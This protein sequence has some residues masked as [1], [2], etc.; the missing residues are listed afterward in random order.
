M[1]TVIKKLKEFT[2]NA[3]IDT[4]IKLSFLALCLF[5]LYTFVL[6]LIS[7]KTF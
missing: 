4:V 2:S 3:I 6:Y 1:I 7:L 5:S